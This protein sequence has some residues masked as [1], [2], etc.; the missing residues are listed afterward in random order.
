MCWVISTPQHTRH[1]LL[2]LFIRQLTQLRMS[3]SFATDLTDLKV[4]MRLSRHLRLMGHAQDLATFPNLRSKRPHVRRCLH[5][6]LRPLR[7]NEAGYL[8]YRCGDHLNGQA[9]ARQL[10]A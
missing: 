5:Q 3:G 6:C 1:F 10:A 2:A 7:Q 9:Y 4:L 8:A